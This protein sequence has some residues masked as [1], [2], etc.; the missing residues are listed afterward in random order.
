MHKDPSRRYVTVEALIRDIDHY[1]RDEPLE[2]RPD[3][4]RYRAEKV[5]AAQRRAW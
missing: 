2:A 5:R 4:T 3:D 1:L